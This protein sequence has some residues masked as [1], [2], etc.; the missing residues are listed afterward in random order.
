MFAGLEQWILSMLQGI[1][2]QFGWLG[3]AGLMVFENAT[4]ITPSELIL[5]LAGWFLIAAQG[6]S[7]PMVF[8]G[9]L[10]AAIGSA[11]GA[12][13]AYWAARLGGRPLID[14]LARFLHIPLRHIDHASALFVRWGPG[15][16]LFGRLA[17]G[18]RTIISIPAGLARMSFG[19]FLLSTF[20]GAYVW[21]SLLIGLGYWFGHEWPRISGIVTQYAPYAAILF[22]LG[23]G[24]AVYV[25]WR[26]RPVE[27]VVRVE[28]E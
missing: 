22:A 17:P 21:C 12:S 11:C 2:E 7:I 4:G 23:A 5:G 20:I 18:I 9:G 3:V 8:I 16:V 19:Q 24:V 28:E 14:R 13:L 6:D 27:E 25:Y 10:Y 15:L 26:R 1:F